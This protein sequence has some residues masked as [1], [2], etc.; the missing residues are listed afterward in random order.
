MLYIIYQLQWLLWEITRISP[1]LSLVSS[2][3]S[4]SNRVELDRALSLIRSDI[5]GGDAKQRE[6]MWRKERL[7][8]ALR[9]VMKCSIKH[10]EADE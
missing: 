2:D 9:H 8:L 6:S 1:K 5:D 4:S 10:A 7:E 3:V